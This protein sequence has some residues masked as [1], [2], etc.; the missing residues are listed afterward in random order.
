M[1]SN[2]SIARPPGFLSDFSMIGGT[3]LISAA[4]AARPLP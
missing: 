4:L 2:T 3:A 1:L